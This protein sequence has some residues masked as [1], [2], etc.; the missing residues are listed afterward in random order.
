MVI[1]A[2]SNDDV[3]Y[4]ILDL[5]LQLVVPDLLHLLERVY[6]VDKGIATLV[7]AAV[8]IDDVFYISAFG[9]LYLFSQL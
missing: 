2:A 9:I 5:F 8:S 1:A 3:F 6:G 4:M 7:I